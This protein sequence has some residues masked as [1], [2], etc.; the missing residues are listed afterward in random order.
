MG[1]YDG[2]VDGALDGVTDGNCEG[3][4]VGD[5]VGGNVVLNGSSQFV[6]IGSHDHEDAS[7]GHDFV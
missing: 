5:C 4:I 6:F 7:N 3:S 2:E 1:V